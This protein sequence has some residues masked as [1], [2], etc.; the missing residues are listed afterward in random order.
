MCRSAD[1]FFV[2]LWFTAKAVPS[3]DYKYKRKRKKLIPGTREFRTSSKIPFP[4][5][6][7]SSI[8]S[9]DLQP[10]NL[11]LSI[12][13]PVVMGYNCSLPIPRTLKC[14]NENTLMH[15]YSGEDRREKKKTRNKR[16]WRMHKAEVPFKSGGEVNNFSGRQSG[17]SSPAATPAHSTNFPN[18]K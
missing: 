18:W 10:S 17:D 7:I 12:D 16:G 8:L 13:Y 2:I 11:S 6:L 9:H 3:N 15:L 4:P 5:K 14:C 1:L